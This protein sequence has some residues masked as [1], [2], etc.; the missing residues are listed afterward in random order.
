MIRTKNVLC[1]IQRK[2]IFMLKRFV[3]ITWNDK[4][5]FDKADWDKY[6]ATLGTAAAIINHYAADAQRLGAIVPFNI[7]VTMPNEVY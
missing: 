7:T 4:Y 6:S 3:S 1:Q 2:V 5:D